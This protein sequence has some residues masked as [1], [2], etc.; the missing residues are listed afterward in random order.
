M[1]K[2]VFITTYANDNYIFAIRLYAFCPLD[3]HFPSLHGGSAIG[4]IGKTVMA[5]G[6]NS[7]SGSY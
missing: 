4:L 5:L 7:S 3:D 2:I 1:L 6:D